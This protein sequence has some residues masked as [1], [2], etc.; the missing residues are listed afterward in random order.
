MMQDHLKSFERLASEADAQFI[1]KI[2]AKPIKAPA[3]SVIDCGNRSLMPGLIDSH[4]HVALSEVFLP[5][6]ETMP[7]ILLTAR[8]AVLL[9]NRLDRGFTSGRDT[10]GADWGLKAAADKW[11]SGAIRCETWASCRSRGRFSPAA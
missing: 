11:R 7:L 5:C 9:C 8:A 3:A 4:G 2:S 6:L 1:K 10:G